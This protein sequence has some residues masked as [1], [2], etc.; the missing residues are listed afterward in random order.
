MK[1]K[2]RVIAALEHR[3]PDRVPTGEN[4]VDERLVEQVL[5]R[6][7]LC[8]GGWRELEALWDGR[9]DEVVTDYAAVHVDLPRALDWDYV[10]VPVVPPASEHVRPRMS[11]PHSWIDEKGRE[12]TFNPAAGSIAVQCHRP[13]MSIDDL[14]D[15]DEPLMV[16]S[17]QL[18]AIRHVVRELG[19][20]H[21][22]IARSPM[23]GPFPWEATVGMEA[24]LIQMIDDPDFVQ[25]A[26]NAYVNRSLVWIK[27]LLDAGVD[28]VM[29]TN[30]YCD[31]RGPIMGVERFREFILPG[32]TRQCEAVHRG[33]GYFI[34][35]T[36]GNV[37]ALLDDFADIGIDGWHGIQTT[38][39]M[40]LRRLKQRYGDGLCFF[41]GVNCETLIEGPPQKAGMEVRYAIEHAA[42][43]GGLVVTCSNVLQ[44]GTK[45]ENYLAMRQAIREFGHYPIAEGSC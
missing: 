37:W 14:P 27:S 42:R 21:F 44:P 32:L 6:P 26:V 7:V 23:D 12:F 22:I 10:R 34:K 38:I 45:L 16:D 36:D 5:G 4:Q 30:D 24:L 8:H 19:H 31:N 29:T 3:E 18:D 11:G 40:D 41:G 1:P 43:G 9:R 33:G 39:G 25:R 28:A 13:D 2:D 20:S 17:T 15:P 35:H